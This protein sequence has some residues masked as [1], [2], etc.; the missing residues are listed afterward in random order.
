MLCRKG[1][2]FFREC[3]RDFMYKAEALVEGNVFFFKGM[4]LV[5]EYAFSGN[6]TRS[7]G[8]QLPRREH[9]QG[10][11]YVFIGLKGMCFVL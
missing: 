11:W 1:M 3:D 2:I 9:C 8:P 6:V 10:R 4:C 5:L 7:C